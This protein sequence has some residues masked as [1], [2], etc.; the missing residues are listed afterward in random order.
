ML[1]CVAK[2][3]SDISEDTVA[4]IFNPFMNIYPVIQLHIPENPAKA[5]KI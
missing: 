1:W 5:E 3:A 2:V 4:Y